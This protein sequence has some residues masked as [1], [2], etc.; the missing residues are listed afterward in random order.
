MALS[1][2][3]GFIEL[4]CAP[5]ID[6]DDTL[7]KKARMMGIFSVN[8][9]E[10]TMT[11]LGC[12]AF[13]ITLVP[14]YATLGEEAML[15]ILKETQLKCVVASG[16]VLKNLLD[17][18][19]KSNLEQIISL[20]PVPSE[21]SEMNMENEHGK[22]VTILPWSH[23]LERGAMSTIDQEAHSPNLDSV[24]TICYTSG[25]TGNPKGV[26]Q[27]HG[28][29]VAFVASA[30]EGP[31]SWESVVLTKDEVHISYLPLAHVFERVVSYAVFTKAAK[32]GYYTGNVSKLIDDIKE[33]KPTVLVSVPRLF[34]K[35]VETVL[36]NVEEKNWISRRLFDRGM[37]VKMRSLERDGSVTNMFW[38]RVVFAKAK[39]ILGGR[40]RYCLCGGAPLDVE[41]QKK[42]QCVMCVPMCV[43]FGM[44]ESTAN[45]ITAPYENNFG[46][47]G[48]CFPSVQFKLK[49][50]PEMNCDAKIEPPRGELCLRGAVICRGYFKNPTASKESID[51]GGWLHT[52][53]VAMLLPGNSIKIVDRK[54]AL[55]KL[56]QGEYISPEK[57]EN[58]YNQCRHISQIFVTGRTN[59]NEP[60][61]IVVPE[62]INAKDI[63]DTIAEELNQMGISANLKGFEKVKK[64]KLTETAFTVEN[65]LLTP[66]F[67]LRRAQLKQHF[68]ADIA[69]LYG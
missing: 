14:L 5:S 39:A 57:I 40:L 21:L 18:S 24:S 16:A 22:K 42:I 53:D 41:I 69:V 15:H 37:A 19:K 4:D 62:D 48:A 56:S 61:A 59:E 36:K 9:P 8:R 54:K 25:T 29:F 27:T 11:D 46:H 47:I 33:L 20:D 43:G 60:V 63:Q 23:V 67:K 35:I 45:M 64:F 49:S 6:Y 31:L 7:V 66:S 2:G 13:H 52:G 1:A 34:N 68:E 50:I 58:V 38:D 3:K 51:E 55:F 65:N 30:F 44:T 28:N 12:A 10:W 26:V 32:I 17:I